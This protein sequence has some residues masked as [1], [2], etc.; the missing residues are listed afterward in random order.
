MDGKQELMKWVD[1]VR[2][3]YW[4]EQGVAIASEYSFFIQ[5]YTQGHKVPL[6]VTINSDISNWWNKINLN[7]NSVFSLLNI[8]VWEFVAQF[9]L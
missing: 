2:G 6:G 4:E 1:G 5:G 9:N 7:V 3:E 8:F